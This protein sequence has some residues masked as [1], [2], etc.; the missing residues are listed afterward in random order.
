LVLNQKQIYELFVGNKESYIEWI[1]NRWVRRF[2]A[3]TP[4]TIKKHLAFDIAVGSYPIY[5]KD[6]IDCCK[7]V[8]IDIDSHRR[9]SKE[10][11]AQLKI[12]YP[13]TW[14][15]EF[16]KL[17]KKYKG[18]IDSVRKSRQK[19]Y[20]DY[21][22]EHSK[23]YLFTDKLL[24]E[25]SGGGFHIW[26][27]PE[28]Y[29]LLEDCG[30]YIE[31]IKPKL[32]EIYKEFFPN[33]GDIEI[34]PKQYSTVHLGEKCG[35]GVRIPFGKNIGKDYITRVLHMNIGTTPITAISQLYTGPDVTRIKEDV[36]K[37]EENELYDK[38]D[39]RWNLQFWYYYPRI[40]PCYQK[41]MDGQLQTLDRH[42]H[43][44]RVSMC[45]ELDYQ[46]TPRHIIP[47]LFEKQFDYELTTSQEQVDSILGGK[48]GNWRWSCSKI[49]ELGYCTEGENCHYEFRTYREGKYKIRF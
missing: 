8:C 32:N 6:G 42:G 19:Q 2:S 12:D 43:M 33:N 9:V 18:D 4:H 26:I 29:T 45:H 30:K 22:V 39:V 11:E 5:Q 31:H 40:R 41:I 44:M 17:I 21:I 23:K 28:S 46:N 13:K 38:Q 7:W 25:D 10:E 35:N 14:R 36:G 3:L 27:F 37:R 47:Q 48:T 34:Y 49:K 20:C 24:Y 16:H 15:V 1:N